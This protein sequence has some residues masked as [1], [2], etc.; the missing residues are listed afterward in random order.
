M[1]RYDELYENKRLQTVNIEIVKG[2]L[3]LCMNWR[4][5]RMLSKLKI[6]RAL[7]SRTVKVPRQPRGKARTS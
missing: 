5:L 1:L 2:E 6:F 4:L 3:G 7:L